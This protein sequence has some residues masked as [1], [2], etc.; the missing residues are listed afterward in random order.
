VQNYLGDNYNLEDMDIESPKV[1]NNDLAKNFSNPFQMKN[2]FGD[3]QSPKTFLSPQPLSQN[4]NFNNMF[5]SEFA[6]R[7]AFAAMF[8]PTLI[9][10]FNNIWFNDMKSSFHNSTQP[11]VGFSNN[12]NSFANKQQDINGSYSHFQSQNQ[13]MNI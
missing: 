8:N 5:S 13:V 1:I 2:Y 4:F 12:F 9:Q 6:Q 7:T 11:S 10:T 3:E